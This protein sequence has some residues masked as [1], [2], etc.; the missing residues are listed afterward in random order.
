MIHENEH[1]I[2]GVKKFIKLEAELKMIDLKF[3]FLNTSIAV[4][5]E[6]VKS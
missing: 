1:P 3:K 2:L 4:N 6:M 5:K